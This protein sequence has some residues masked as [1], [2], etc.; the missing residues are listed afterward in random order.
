MG[1]LVT[2]IRTHVNFSRIYQSGQLFYIPNC[3]HWVSQLT[4][5]LG[6]I[7][8][9]LYGKK[10]Q[11]GCPLFEN[12]PSA[13]VLS[14]SQQSHLPC[15]IYC[16]AYSL[17]RPLYLLPT[18]QLRQLAL[19]AVC[20]SRWAR[21]TYNIWIEFFFVISAKFPQ[22]RRIEFKLLWREDKIPLALGRRAKE[23]IFEVER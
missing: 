11:I 4:R 8:Q 6:T 3:G 16:I 15:V 18:L 5:G 17:G 9:P 22:L 12:R 14:N 1:F 10:K 20:S 21:L 23:D 19:S 13:S 7:L 2:N